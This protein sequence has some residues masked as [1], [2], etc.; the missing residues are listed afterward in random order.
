MSALRPATTALSLAVAA[1]ALLGAAA[2]P[3][4][5]DTPAQERAVAAILDDWHAAAAAADEERYFAHMTSD[6]VFLGTDPTERWTTPQ[7]RAYAHP[8]F[9]KGKAWSFRSVRRDVRISPDGSTAWFDE[10]LATP[11]LGPARGSGVLVREGRTWKIA[12][13]DLSVPIPNAVFPKVKEIIA[14]AAPSSGAHA[15]AGM[16]RSAE[17][18]AAL[19]DPRS[20]FWEERSPDTFMV[21]VETSTGT[22]VVEAHRNWAPHGCDRF[23]N[24]VRAGFFDDSR[25]FRVRRGS[26]AQFGI[27]GEPAVAA[28]WRAAAIPDDPPRVSNTRGTVAYAMTGPNTRTTQLFV[29]LRDN[30]G[31]DAEGFAPIGRVVEGMDAVDRLYAGYGDGAG[32]GMRGGKQG[33]IFAGGDAYLDREFPLLDRLIRATIVA[34]RG[35]GGK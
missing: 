22:F 35:T 12:Q 4:R 13:Y 18:H 25:F 33:P 3:G 10:D 1:A 17:A 16:P 30:P 9:A 11:N 15:P 8:Y 24:L 28:V 26:F 20:A 6:A 32:G 2:S 14:A 5:S 7:F 29:N 19:A 21:K 27:P 34:P 23:Y 31:Y